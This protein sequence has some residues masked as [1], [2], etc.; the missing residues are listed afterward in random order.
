MSAFSPLVMRKAEAASSVGDKFPSGDNARIESFG[1]LQVQNLQ[2]PS[3]RNGELLV[4]FRAGTSQSDKEIVATT[5]GA[6]RKKQLSGESAVEKL[7]L[8]GNDDAATVALQLSLNPAVEFA[9]PNFLI[10]KDQLSTTPNDSRFPEQWALGNTGQN[11]GQFGSDIGVTKAW[12]MTTGKPATVIAIIDSGVDFTHP[13]LINNEWTNL[14]PTNGDVHGWDYVTNRGDIK[15]EQGHGTAIAGIIAAEG[16]NATG[17]SGVMWRANLMSLRVLDNTGT[18]DIGNA[19]EAIDYAVAHGAQVINLSWGTNGESLALKDAIARAIGRD[20]V[21]VCSAGNSGQDLT[22]APYY[23]ASF[24]IGDLIAVAGTDNFDR[25]ASWSNWGDGKVMLAAP[26][27]SILTTKMGGGYWTVDGTSA[28]APLVTGVAGLIKSARPSLNSHNVV[29]ALKDGARKVA[30]LSGKVSSGGVV[31]ASGALEQLRDSANQSPPLPRPTRGSGGTGPGGSFNTTPPPSTTGA[32]ASNLP[33]LDQ[34]RNSK[35]ADPKAK[36]P[37]QSNL[38]CADCDPLGGGGGGGYYPAGDPNFSTARRRPVNETGHPGVDLGSRNFNWSAPLLS[39]NG[40]AGLDLNLTLFYNS[41]VWTKDGSYIKYNADLGTPAPGFR[42]GLPTLQQRFLN[43]QTGIY[44]YMMVTPAGDRVELRQVGSSNIYEAQDGSYTQLD[45]TNPNALIARSSD[46]TQLTFTPVT[47]NSEYRCT[48]I[49]DRNG[50]Y[51][52]ATYDTTNGHLQTITDTLSRVVTFV[53]DANSNLIAIRQTWAGVAHDWATFSYGQVYVAPNFGGGL[54]VNGPNNN[55]VTVLTQVSLHDGSYFTFNYNS[56]FGQ[57]NRINHYATDSHLLS[58]TSYNVDSSAG[59]TECPRFTEQRDWAENW[60]NGAEAVTSYSVATDNSWSQQTAPDGTIFKEFFATSGWQ[61]GLTTS[62]EIWSGGV[63]KKWT[64]MAWTQDDTGLSYQKNPRVTESNIYDEAGNRRR[65]EIAYTSFNLPNPVALPT[66]VKE[67]AADG[68]TVLRRTTK[69]YFYNQAYIDRRVLGLL[70]EVMVYDENNQPVSKV[71]YDYDWGNEYWEATPQAATQHDASGD[72]TGR[73]NLC[74]IGRWDVSDINNFDKASR[75]YIKYNRTGS[76]IRKEDHYGRGSTVSY[77]DSYSDNANRN[78]FAYPTTVTDADNFVSTAQYN[79]DFGAVTRTQDPKGAVQNI[80]YDSVA[81]LDR[82]T[83]AVNNAYMRYVYGPTYVQSFSSVT[84]V[85][86]D[87]YAISVFDGA[88]RSMGTVT[89]HPGSAGGYS[90]VN[91]IYDQMGRVVKRSNPT[92]INSAW[93][94][95][96]DDASGMLYT[97]QTY[98]WKGRPLL[99]TNPDGTTRELTYGGCGCAGGEVTTMR[100]ENGRRRKFTKD[101]LGRLKQVDELNWDQSV[102]STTTY[103]YNAR[104]QITGTSQAGQPRSFVYDGHGRLQTRTT[105]EQGPTSY[106]YFADDAVQTITDARGATTTLAYNNRHLPTS[107]TYGVPAGV[108]ATANVSFGYDAAGNRTSMTDGLGSVSYSYNTLSQLTSET[109]TFTGVGSFALSYAY[110]LVGELNSI[111]NP[112]STQI[113]YN[114]DTVGRPTAVTGSGYGGV[115][116]YVGSMAYRAFG[117]K[118]M[119]YGNS[120]TLSLQYDNRLRL[121]Q[122][123]L[124]GVLRMRYGYAWESTGRVEFVRNV[125]DETLDRY[126]GYD[127]VGRLSVS[128]SGSEARLAVGEQVPLAYDGPYSHGYQYDQFGNITY[129]EGW[130]GDNPSFTATYTNNRRN[131]LTYD[132]GGNLTNDGGQN[133][134]Y[135]TTGQQASASYSGY[136]LQQYYD[137]DRLRGE[138]IDNGAATYYLRSSVL[139][140]QVVA[141]INSSGALQRGYVYLDGELLA[142]QQNN[143][144]SWIHQEPVAKS[145]RVTNSSGTVISTIELDPFGGNTNRN[146]ND[147]F[148]PHRFTTYERDANASDEAM[149]RRYNRWW[150]RFDQPDPYD[151]SY[152]LTNPQSFNRYAY[153][154]NDPVNFVDPTGLVCAVIWATPTHYIELC[155]GSGD[156]GGGGVPWT[157]DDGRGGGGGGQK[158]PKPTPKPTPTRQ[159]S[160]AQNL[161]D[162]EDCLK[163]VKAVFDQAHRAIPNVFH[164]SLPS[165]KAVGGIL[166][167]TSLRTAGMAVAVGSI[168]LTAAAPLVVSTAT[169]AYAGAWV[170]NV[171]SNTVSNAAQR[172]T[173][174][175]EEFKARMACRAFLD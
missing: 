109:R 152:D 29:K 169:A 63:K 130:G 91:L 139:G 137:G 11:G 72:Q 7:E 123:D 9:E 162:Y 48:Q 8:T 120:R 116:S 82:V 157:R 159:K 59:Q 64:T 55:Y 154:Q 119:A 65:A 175:G 99:T 134:S 80:T 5:H 86:D 12:Q 170:V 33:N 53:Y 13:D 6:H 117:L 52:S 71:W 163:N 127:H 132:A 84:T 1:L 167:V 113:G 151:G 10:A 67:Y 68:A 22:V 30:S 142:V 25:L 18:G 112:W 85:T 49:K 83:N 153:V 17:I 147:A 43:S 173:L 140:G 118:Q 108:A 28:S 57:V 44:A 125:D 146:S 143:Q 40:R 150:S 32:P 144:V 81:R 27:T 56:A 133:F 92:E 51:I 172:G 61:N 93:V 87:A 105:P 31:S 160:Q 110:N 36:A 3:Y 148:Q 114:Y 66:E 76:V 100:D 34:V 122:W 4:R 165:A 168:S 155:D 96:G 19:V 115:S 171:A 42:L 103:A 88:G 46:G 77:A 126:Y 62:T 174:L 98:D 37:I 41:L 111:T 138:K 95:S 135:D 26:G 149:Q 90:M 20:V 141:E 101:V 75:A 15:D 69:T 54:L 131:G 38:M 94:P 14:T 58:Y 60:N 164:N 102:Y 145:K 128:R 78:T 97:Q 161:K 104:D 158:K 136:L 129:R 50:N 16:N 73:G 47:I 156:S 2:T 24:G 166:L 45:V 21:V 74:W 79:Y 121:T 35:P 70:R 23:P 39:L 106:T 89:N 124:P 107:I